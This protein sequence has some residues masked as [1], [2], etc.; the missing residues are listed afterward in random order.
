MSVSEAS[1][2]KISLIWAMND[3]RVIGIKN[4]LPW[5]LSADMKW[6]RRHTL[7]K[8][9]IMGRKTYES[10]GSKALPDRTN[11]IISRKPDYQAKDAIVTASFDAAVKAAGEADEIMVIGGASIYE[12]T[13]GLA[14]RLYMTLV[15]GDV[16]GDA[17]FPEF[18]KSAWREIH[19]EDHPADAKNE[20]PYSFIIL[21]RIFHEISGLEKNRH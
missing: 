13:L 1:L 3:Q 4:S 6:F 16:E 17:W 11:I 8:P 12:Q 10:F 9:V 5:K 20:Y 7:G 21:A 15:H 18:D 19:R 2:G 14:D